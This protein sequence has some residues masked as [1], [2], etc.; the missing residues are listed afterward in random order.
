[1]KASVIGPVSL[2]FNYL[3]DKLVR[4]GPGGVT[5]FAGNAL[6]NL[7][8]K[9]TVYGS[10]RKEHDFS[11]AFGPELVNIP[12]ER[13]VQFVNKVP[14]PESPDAR[15]QRARAGGLRISPDDLP[16]EALDVDYIVLG[17]LIYGDIDL[18]FVK[19]LKGKAKI[20]LA[21]QGMIRFIEDE[22]IA[23]RLPPDLT[24]ILRL[25]DYVFCDDKELLQIS[26]SSGVL[27]SAREIKKCCA[28]SLIV[29]MGQRGSILFLG[30]EMIEIPAFKP[31]KII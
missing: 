23:I 4:K 18:E 15:I 7:G 25:T 29:T 14:D 31:R 12:A 11:G 10:Y 3:G 30:K 1:M 9:T 27:E 8:V 5:F 22:R 16:D 20:V 21:L 17:P 2:D 26:K 24:D 19:S 28:E 6:H 13:T